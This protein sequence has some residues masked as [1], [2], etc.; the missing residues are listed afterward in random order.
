MSHLETTVA[1]SLGFAIVWGSLTVALINAE[2]TR[3]I[4]D[5]IKNRVRN[6]FARNVIGTHPVEGSLTRR[7]PRRI[8]D[9]IKL[10]QI[11]M[12]NCDTGEAVQFDITDISRGGMG[13]STDRMIALD[14]E[15]ELQIEAGDK[16]NGEL[17]T[18]IMEARWCKENS[19]PHRFTAGFRGQLDA[20][21]DDLARSL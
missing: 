12:K 20:I 5:V 4:F 7:E 3:Y 21:Y 17:H 15:F 14:D 1:L 13:V 9:G 2:D 11:S 6:L 8:L 10:Y 18:T 19:A 16:G